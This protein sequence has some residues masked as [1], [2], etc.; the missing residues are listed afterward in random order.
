MVRGESYTSMS[1][2]GNSAAAVLSE[3]TSVA[4]GI[5]AGLLMAAVLGCGTESQRAAGTDSAEPSVTGQAPAAAGAHRAVVTLEPADA[6]SVPLPESP[7]LMDQY[8]LSFLPQFL[9]VRAGQTVE[10]RN[11]EEVSH[12]VRVV[13]V[14]TDST[15][16]NVATPQGEPYLHLFTRTGEHTVTCDIH[17]GMTAF[18]LVV[19]AS[20][21]TVAEEDGAFAFSDVPPGAYTLRVWH[22][23][24]TL[25]STRQV[26]IDQG[27]TAL[28]L[29][30]VP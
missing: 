20:Y 18:I 3:M 22:P 19:E 17:P 26:R 9:V 10:F 23:E 30:S 12:N 5:T 21:A 15:L 28:S 14:G 4:Q 13:A 25:R 24:E 7:V 1:P 8:A 27:H 16:F 6:P 11:S 29:D 2:P